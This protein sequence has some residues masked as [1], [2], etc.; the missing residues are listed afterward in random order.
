MSRSQNLKTEIETSLGPGP[1]ARGNTVLRSVTD[2]FVNRADDYSD[3]QV[4]VF[5]DVMQCLLD[6]TEHD[7]KV[8]LSSRLAPISRAPAKVVS[9][10]LND[11]DPR[12]STP[13]LAKSSS[14]SDTD[15]SAIIAAGAAEQ[16]M[17]IARRPAI[18]KLVTEKLIARAIP[19]VTYAVLANEGAQISETSIVKLIGECGNDAKLGPLVAARK[20]LP[21]ELRPFLDAYQSEK[22]QASKVIR[23]GR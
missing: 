13:M 23:A 14:V 5:D 12:V 16:L 2:L 11:K 20:D 6:H 8:E 9:T 10:L 17:M 19:D 21:E 15:L 3:E 1:S 22:P 18:N 7:A 4:S